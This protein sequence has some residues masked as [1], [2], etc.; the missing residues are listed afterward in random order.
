MNLHWI[1][2]AQSAAGLTATIDGATI[3]LMRFKPVDMGRD[4]LND[5]PVLRE[6]MGGLWVVYITEGDRF[7]LEPVVYEFFLCRCNANQAMRRAEGLAS[8]FVAWRDRDAIEAK[9]TDDE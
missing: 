3:E 8:W 4:E 9:G 6:F 2:N 7:Q 5:R 1:G